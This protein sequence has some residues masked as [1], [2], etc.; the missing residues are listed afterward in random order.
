MNVEQNTKK[1]D[2]S[3]ATDVHGQSLYWRGAAGRVL[4]PIKLQFRQLALGIKKHAWVIFAVLLTAGVMEFN[5]YQ[6][7]LTRDYVR[8]LLLNA[9]R[10]N[11]DIDALDA[12]LSQLN[13]KIDALSAKLDKPPVPSSAVSTKPRPSILPRLR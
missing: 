7:R 8:V 2:I 5:Y 9:A 6:A 4:K 13:T 12:K 10:I 3:F 1:P 11:G